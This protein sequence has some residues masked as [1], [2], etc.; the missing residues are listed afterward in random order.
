MSNSFV[1]PEL[2]AECSIIVQT[3]HMPLMPM[4][5]V[6]GAQERGARLR[7]GRPYSGGRSLRPRRQQFTTDC[8]GACGIGCDNYSCDDLERNPRRAA[9]RAARRRAENRRLEA[10]DEYRQ[11]V[12]NGNMGNNLRVTRQRQARRG[13][14]RRIRWT[15]PRGVGT[16]QF[17]AAWADVFGTAAHAATATATTDTE[18]LEGSTNS[19]DTETSGKQ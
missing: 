7:A 19:S 10:L 9:R 3:P 17:G 1:D 4:W 6:R 14:R 16:R 11:N 8:R 18:P 13:S 12:I 2:A 5:L 15:S